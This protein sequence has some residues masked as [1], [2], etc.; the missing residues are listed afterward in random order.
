MHRDGQ[1]CIGM[2]RNGWEC[3][4]M[5]R[6]MHTSAFSKLS[7]VLIVIRTISGNGFYVAYLVTSEWMLHEHLLWRAGVEGCA[8]ARRV[9]V[10][11]VSSMVCRHQGAVV[12]RHSRSL[13]MLVEHMLWCTGVEGRADAHITCGCLLSI[14]YPYTIS[15]A[16]GSR[17]SCKQMVPQLVDA[18]RASALLVGV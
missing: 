15:S 1:G 11:F 10:I 17:C 5:H 7:F 13:W 6:D 18:R 16:P 12:S 4:G 14:R 8:D 9:S 3:I 2:H